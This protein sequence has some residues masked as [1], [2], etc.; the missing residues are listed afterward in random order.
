MSSTGTPTSGVEAELRE[1]TAVADVPPSTPSEPGLTPAPGTWSVGRFDPRVVKTLTVLGFALPVVGYI[2]LVQHYQVNAIWQDQ[3]DDINVIRHFPQW[4]S[5]WNQ[6]TDNRVLFPNLIVVALAHTVHY[7]IDVEE[8]LGAL[9]LFG[10]TALFIWSHKRRSPNT[11]LLFYCPVAFLTLTLSQWQNALWGFQTAW[12]LVL[13]SLAVTIALLDRPQAAGPLGW[14][15]LAWPTFVVA[16][17]AAVVGSYSSLQGLLIWP[18]GLVLLYHRRWPRWA[19]FGWIAAAGV[20]AVLYFLNFTTTR[21]DNPGLALS[22]SWLAVRVFLFA[23]GDVVGVQENAQD[24]P[25]AAVMAFG[26]V[27]FVVAV[28][29]LIRW[30]IRRDERSGAPIGIALIVYGLLFDALMT[31]GRF[32]LKFHAASQSRYTTNNV[33]VLA[34]IYLT[35]LS[36]TRLRARAPREVRSSGTGWQLKQPFMWIWGHAERIDGRVVR[37]IALAA[38]VVQVAFSVPL[39][40]KDARDFHQEF[41]TSVSVAANVEHEPDS[42]VVRELYFVQ[43]PSWIRAQVQFAREHHLSQF[44]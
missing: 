42:V 28:F 5:L 44:R 13:L 2:A 31:Q 24:A 26:I 7:N 19:F 9:M 34:G 3:W 6:H 30:G 22:H 18:V 20:T 33:L 32:W 23:L 43:S 37:Q 27:I 21:L 41:L 36:A 15:R 16:A 12:Y 40:V 35:V 1:T 25:N 29:V 17:L 38:I 14:P 4:S 39:G 10:A 8:Y 11:P